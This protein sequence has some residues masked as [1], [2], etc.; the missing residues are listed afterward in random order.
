[1][2]IIHEF[3]VNTILIASHPMIPVNSFG[4]RKTL[5]AASHARFK[6]W[7]GNEDSRIAAA[8][9]SI[10]CCL[11]YLCAAPMHRGSR[12]TQ[13]GPPAYSGVGMREA[14]LAGGLVSRHSDLI[15][16]AAQ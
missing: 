9:R 10:T 6:L 7:H 15:R 4:M 14:G 8:E 16:G 1:M 3:E 5:F 13:F 11:L 12:Q 2:S